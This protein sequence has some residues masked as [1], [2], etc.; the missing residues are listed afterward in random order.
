MNQRR[1][2]RIG[3]TADIHGLFDPAIR[4]HFRG[5]DHILHAGDIGD[6]S[7]IEQLEQIAPV[8]GV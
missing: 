2:I 3:V 7:V 5:V 6:L 8:T 1:A 4:R